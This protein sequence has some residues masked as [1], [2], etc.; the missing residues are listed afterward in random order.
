M[1]LVKRVFR[2]IQREIKAANGRRVASRLN[3]TLEQPNYMYK[4]EFHPNATVVDIGCADDPDL[5]IHLMEKYDVTAFG[6]DPTRKH[7]ESLSAVEAKYR[8]FK[9]LRYAVASE[10]A[11]LVFYESLENASGSLLSNH[12]N[13]QNDTVNEYEVDALTIPGIIAKTNC[14]VV[15]YLK[16][17]LEGAEY[18]LLESLEESDLENVKQVFVEFHHHCIDDRTIVDTKKL[19][20]KLCSFGYTAFTTDNA[21]YL[22]Y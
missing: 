3:L 1:N 18:A 10:N 8:K 15:D 13:V 22:F 21:N 17:D 14:K 12:S 11:R 2:K 9:H 5:S 7:F 4:S 16:I 19:V 6:V 20:E